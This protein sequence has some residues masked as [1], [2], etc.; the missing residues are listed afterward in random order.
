MIQGITT[1]DQT[2]AIC[3]SLEL[4]RA[5]LAA[6]VAAK[7]AGRFMIRS[8]SLEVFAPSAQVRAR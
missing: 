3:R 6:A 7:P 8:N 5:A 4:A 2:L 1:L